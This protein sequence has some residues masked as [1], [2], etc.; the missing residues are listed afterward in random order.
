M[1]NSNLKDAKNKYSNPAIFIEKKSK[2][3]HLSEVIKLYE[4]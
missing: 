2:D 4:L 1:K 3:F